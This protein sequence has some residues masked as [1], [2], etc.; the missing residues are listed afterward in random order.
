MPILI[1][2]QLDGILFWFRIQIS[3]TGSL[4]FYDLLW[5]IGFA[6]IIVILFVR[7]KLIEK[8][9]EIEDFDVVTHMMWLFVT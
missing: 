9:W 5:W 1:L 3:Q 4:K 6:I 2:G 7:V 8:N